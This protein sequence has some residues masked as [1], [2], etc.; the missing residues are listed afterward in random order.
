[1]AIEDLENEEASVIK[2]AMKT[3]KNHYGL[4]PGKYAK[5]VR[6]IGYQLGVEFSKIL[7]TNSTDL[8]RI[9]EE[10][11]CY[12]VKH[13]IGEIRWADRENMLVE[14]KYCSDCFSRGYG[15][16]YTLCPFKEGLLKAVLEEKTG[17]KFEV[18]EME[19]CGTQSNN[20]LFK[21]ERDV[22]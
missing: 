13:A 22:S 5:P 12:W 14:M 16:G 6:E 11:G 21:V 3:L 4:N 18:L 17:N 10:M 9:I 8:D 20:C 2:L 15:A 19:C 1:M 7:R